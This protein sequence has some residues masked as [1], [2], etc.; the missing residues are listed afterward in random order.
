[1]FY[2]LLLNKEAAG[3]SAFDDVSRNAWYYDAVITLANMGIITVSYTHLEFFDE[4]NSLLN[5]SNKA[6]NHN[7]WVAQHDTWLELN[8]IQIPANTAYV[9]IW[10]SN[11][12]SLA[13][14]PFIGDFTATLTDKTAP[15]YVET[16]AVSEAGTYHIGE[17]IR[18]RVAMNEPVTVTNGGTL[19][20]NIGNAVYAGQNL[21]D[22]SDVGQYIY[23]DLTITDSL[24]AVSNK[25]EIKP[26]S[27][28]GLSVADDAGNTALV[29]TNQ[30]FSVSDIYMD[31]QYPSVTAV[32]LYSCLL[33]T[34]RCV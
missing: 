6:T 10:F 9:R 13:G 31:N 5:D 16:T 15:A 34:S 22:S 8:E 4:N 20:T 27:L 19:E 11:W 32:S 24:A 29:N 17:T 12:G 14:R 28:S 23:Y 3:V 7:Y 1:M 25:Y 18:L 21:G 2:N 30:N 33:Y 26:V